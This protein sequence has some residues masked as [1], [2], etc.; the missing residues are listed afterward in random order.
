[1]MKK[2]VARLKNRFLAKHTYKE[3]QRNMTCTVTSTL[4][5][6]EDEPPTKLVQAVRKGELETMK[7]LKVWRVT[8]RLEDEKV[9]AAHWVNTKQKGDSETQNNRSRH[10]GRELTAKRLFPC[11]TSHGATHNATDTT[12]HTP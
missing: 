9:A 10:V 8:V 3:K 2:H 4:V 5:T 12:E 11:S 1:M 7:D 6:E